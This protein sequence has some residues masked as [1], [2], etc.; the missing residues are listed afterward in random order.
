MQ[1]FNDTDEARQAIRA[2][3]LV[4]TRELA[5]QVTDNIKKLLLYCS[6]DI[7]VANIAGNIAPQFQK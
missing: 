2:L 7:N 6:Q 4:P 1:A 5:E 3:I